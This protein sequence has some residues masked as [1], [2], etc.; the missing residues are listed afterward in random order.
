RPEGAVLLADEPLSAMDPRRSL[1]SLSLIRELAR[2]G[3]AVALVLHDLS[4]AATWADHAL[5]LSADARA[6][7]AGPAAETLDQANL[8]ALF[9]VRFERLL[10]S[11]GSVAMAAQGASAD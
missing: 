8:R 9:G 7:G 1:E 4:L 2:D 6:A 11:D 10:A 3:V 5:L